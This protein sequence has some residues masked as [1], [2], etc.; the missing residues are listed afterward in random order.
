MTRR[1]FEINDK[2]IRQ[3]WTESYERKTPM[4]TKTQYL[5]SSTYKKQKKK[6]KTKKLPAENKMNAKQALG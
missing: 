5:Y 4:I 6:G 3:R 2:Q 1:R